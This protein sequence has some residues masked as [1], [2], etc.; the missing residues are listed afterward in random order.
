M[1]EKTEKSE[2]KSEEDMNEVEKAMLEDLSLG[3]GEEVNELEQ[4]ENMIQ[5][6]MCCN[7]SPYTCENQECTVMGVCTSCML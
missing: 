5:L 6:C 7:G 4:I 3:E 1:K 2:K